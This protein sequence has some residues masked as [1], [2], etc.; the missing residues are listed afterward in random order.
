M[1]IW[2]ISLLLGAC[3]MPRG[4]YG[5]RYGRGC[6]PDYEEHG[7]RCWI[8][9]CSGICGGGRIPPTP[10]TAPMTPKQLARPIE[11]VVGI[12]VWLHSVNCAAKMRPKAHFLAIWVIPVSRVQPRRTVLVSA[13]KLDLLA[14][15]FVSP[16]SHPPDMAVPLGLQSRESGWSREEDDVGAVLDG[17]NST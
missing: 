14:T 2:R 9:G 7:L 10:D 8:C 16:R 1:A 6:Q 3:G 11:L 13:L 17:G 4:C 5:Q 15:R 12:D